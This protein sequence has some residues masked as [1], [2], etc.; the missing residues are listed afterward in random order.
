MLR[1]QRQFVIDKVKAPLRKVLILVAN[2]LPEITKENTLHPNTHILIDLKDKFLEYE[3]N[4][5]RKEMLKAG[6]KMFIAEY[7]HDPFYRY[8]FDWLIEEIVNS[9]WKPRPVGHPNLF[10]G[11]PEPYGGGY[12]I[13]DD[14]LRSY[15]NRRHIWAS[16]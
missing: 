11:E 9:D 15:K 2:R 4:P 10:W 8:R 1:T 3:T 14:K 13:K 7:E 6:W 12:L 16:Q 5:E